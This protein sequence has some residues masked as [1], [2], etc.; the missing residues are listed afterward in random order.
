MLDLFILKEIFHGDVIVEEVRL[1]QGHHN[2]DNL[3][4]FLLDF[5]FTFVVFELSW[6]ADADGL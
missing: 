3:P 5:L 2:W 1:L 4:L 6:H